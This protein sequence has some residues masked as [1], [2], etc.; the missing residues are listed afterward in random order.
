MNDIMHNRRC[1]N[2]NECNKGRPG[3]CRKEFKNQ[4]SIQGKAWTEDI[5]RVRFSAKQHATD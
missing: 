4:L 2:L 5:L 3:F 1:A